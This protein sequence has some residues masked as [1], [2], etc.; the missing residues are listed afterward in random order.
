MV[1]ISRHRYQFPQLEEKLLQPDVRHSVVELDKPLADDFMEF[2]SSG[3]VYTKYDILE[4]LPKHDSPRFSLSDFQAKI[5][6]PD[7]VLVTYSAVKNDANGQKSSS[8]RSSIWKKNGER[9]QIVFHQGTI[10]TT[11]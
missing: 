8:L 6:A 5:L 9:W 3:L 1:F 4:S 7:M 11:K 2:G 10:I